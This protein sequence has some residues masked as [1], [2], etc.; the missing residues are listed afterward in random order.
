MCIVSNRI[1][2]FLLP[3]LCSLGFH[4]LAFFALIYLLNGRPTP[5]TV[6]SQDIIVAFGGSSSTDT[7]KQ[8]RTKTSKV[9]TVDPQASLSAVKKTTPVMPHLDEQLLSPSHYLGYLKELINLNVPPPYPYEARMRGQEGRVTVRVQFNHEG[10]LDFVKLEQ[11]SG[12]K[13]L[14]EAAIKAIEQWMF[15]QQS[16]LRTTHLLIPVRFELVE[17]K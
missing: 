10:Q 4:G 1:S 13:V 16:W 7:E 9:K 14:D 17:N 6:Y 5:V 11:T 15:P 12:F 2:R 8:K 3:F